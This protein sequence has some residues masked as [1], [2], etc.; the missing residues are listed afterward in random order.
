[1]VR[2]R[3]ANGKDSVTLVIVNPDRYEGGTD[4]KRDAKIVAAILW[5]N[6]PSAV[7]DDVMKDLCDRY[8]AAEEEIRFSLK[9]LFGE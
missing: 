9:G 1:M 6:L 3:A 4:H 8:G 5:D 7:M 2:V